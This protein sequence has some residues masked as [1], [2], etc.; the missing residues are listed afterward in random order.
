MEFGA[1]AR[2]VVLVLLWG[3]LACSVQ[4][5]TTS[6]YRIAP[7]D[8]INV[9]VF[10][11]PDLSVQG[12]PVSSNGSI[13]I[14]LL[15]QVNVEGLSVGELER[16]LTGLFQNGYLRNPKV[17]VILVEYR[18]F[19][20]SGAVTRPGAFSYKE[21]LTV[22]RAVVLAG[23]FTE[24]ALEEKIKIKRSAE[25]EQVELEASADTEIQPGDVIQIG[26]RT[27][28]GLVFYVHGEVAR[29]GA[30]GYSE[31]LTVEKAI[32]IAGGLSKR[33]S[34][35]KIEIVRDTD[36]ERKSVRVKLGDPVEPGD[37]I[38]VGASLF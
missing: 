21:G 8:R 14:P 23:G 15:G 7:G 16:R 24:N 37:I 27:S 9:M 4:A 34:K 31:N 32:T 26:S 35:R 28:L 11:E 36:P 29:P 20:I 25:G 38:T 33:A 5:A 17:T 12:A 10:G 13:T 6:S 18:P 22:G 30:Y 19:Y 3:L 2:F 1:T